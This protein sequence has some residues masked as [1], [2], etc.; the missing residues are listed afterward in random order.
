MLMCLSIHVS[1]SASHRLEGD[2]YSEACKSLH[3]HNYGVDLEISSGML[4]PNGMVVDVG[5]IRN[6][7][8][9]LFDHVD[10]NSTNIFQQGIGTLKGPAQTT[11]ENLAYAIV[12]F[13]QKKLD[14]ALNQSREPRDYIIVDSVTVKETDNMSVTLITGERSERM[15]LERR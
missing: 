3:G 11:A 10:L 15:K 9:A 13:I 8:K 7:L 5:W 1:L 4:D 2:V 14:V 6:E 12:I